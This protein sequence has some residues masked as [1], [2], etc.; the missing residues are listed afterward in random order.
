MNI[1]ADEHISPRI[2]KA[3]CELA[4][5]GSFNFSTLIGNSD[6]QAIEDEDWIDKFGRN[7]GYGVISADRRMLQRPTLIQKIT[8]HVMKAVFLPAEWANSKRVHQASH[9]LYWWPTIEQCF[10]ESP[11]GSAWIVP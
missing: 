1:L 7:G 3:V 2:V 4:L 6:Y 11:S 5:T 10:I 9:I 8:D